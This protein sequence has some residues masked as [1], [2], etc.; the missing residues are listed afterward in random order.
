MG[1]RLQE[2]KQ[3][4]GEASFQINKK[5][6]AEQYHSGA[7]DAEGVR[8]SKLIV[9]IPLWSVPNHPACKTI[10]HACQKPW[11]PF[12]RSLSRNTS[13]AFVT[14]VCLHSSER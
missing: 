13:V 5:Y 3:C 2:P 14:V 1:I 11:V 7:N 4:I 8:L 9:G 12:F 10:K 6:I